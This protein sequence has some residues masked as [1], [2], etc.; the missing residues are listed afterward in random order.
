MEIRNKDSPI[1]Y[2]CSPF[3]GDVNGNFANPKSLSVKPSKIT[4]KVGKTKTIKASA[5]PVKAGKKFINHTPHYRFR[6]DCKDVA[7]VSAK[8]KVK[9]KA[10]GTAKIYVQAE[11]GMWKVVKV[12]VK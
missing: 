7:T 11:N 6:S 4:L 1:I 9:A 2:I 12:T 5:K 3:S 8:G 10:I